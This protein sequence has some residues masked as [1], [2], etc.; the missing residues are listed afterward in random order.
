MAAR[1]QSGPQ[2]P[3][4]RISHEIE[5]RRIAVW[6][7]ANAGAALRVLCAPIGCGKT[8]AA[9][10]YVEG[11]NG[12]AAYVRVPSGVDTPTLR[13]LIAAPKTDEVVLDELDRAEGAACEALHDDVLDGLVACRLIVVGRSRRRLRVQGL[14]ARGLAKA[15]DPA[16]FAFDADELAELAA[17]AGLDH[18]RT[19]L[20]QVLDDT[21]GWPLAAHWLI[22]DALEGQRSLRDA[23]E[24]WR[25]RNAHL[26]FELLQHERYE[27]AEA[28]DAYRRI[29]L[30]G[31]GDAQHELER[32]EQLGL[33]IVRA[34]ALV[35]P[36]RFL[37]RLVAPSGAAIAEPPASD[38]SPKM[39]LNALGRFRCEID[40][41][42]VAFA[43]RRDQQVFVYVATAPEG[44][45]SRDSLL[46]AFWPGLDR[47]AASQSLR[48]TLSR[49]RRAI[50]DAAPNTDPERYFRT[51][52]TL[53]IDT[54]T[55]AVD[56]RRFV[57]HIEQGL[58]DDARGNIDGAKHHY[59]AAHRLYT[60]RLLASEGPEPCLESRVADFESL[61]EEALTRLMSLHAA[62]GEL[63]LARDYARELLAR[64]TAG[65][66]GRAL[67][68]FA[69]SPPGATA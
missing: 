46:D 36:Y 39:R 60:D 62:T 67:D 12:A 25:E 37:V 31:W 30:D 32:L 64:N 15:F 43:R 54:R 1:I 49:I 65:G 51:A 41:R 13:A 58:L 6:L 61:Y 4:G 47:T 29:L 45:T 24:Q 11:R 38:V 28:F 21:E 66:R 56:V 3:P 50:I 7:D 16:A 19:D 9:R 52:G 44:R 53:S 42:P 55:V 8:V 40:G 33:P 69:G 57:D 68:L 10:Q 5:R 26:L 35:R 22:R 27:D 63:D 17:A 20:M 34:G 14:L 59:R 23:F 2:P 48:V 18:E